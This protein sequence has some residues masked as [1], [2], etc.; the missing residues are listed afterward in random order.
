MSNRSRQRLSDFFVQRLKPGTRDVKV[1]DA[2]LPGFGIR[3]TPK[4][5]K[6]W[7]VQFDRGGKK[8][9]ATLGSLETM[10]DGDARKKAKKLR[11]LHDDGVDILAHLTEKNS[12]KDITSVVKTWEQDYAPNLKPSTVDS[13]NS[14]LKTC[15]LPR[16]GKRLVK[17]L[18]LED[19]RAFHKALKDTPTQANRAVAIL[20]RLITIAINEGWRE[21]TNPCH[22]FTRPTEKSKQRTFT[23]NELERL[24]KALTEL[25]AAKELDASVADLVRF[26]A[27][28]GLRSGEALDLTWGAVGESRNLMRFDAHKTDKGGTRPKVLPLNSHLRAILKR[29]KELRTSDYVFPSA[30]TDGRFKGMGKCWDRIREKA[31]LEPLNGEVLTLHDLRRSFRSHCGELGF[32]DSVG[33]TLLGHS[34]GK[35]KDTYIQYGP[36]GILG[37]ASQAT[38]DWMAKAMKGGKPKVGERVKPTTSNAAQQKRV[39]S[40]NNR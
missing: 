5:V 25:V 16:L 26:I 6:S 21:T 22:K 10:N 15:I 17:D 20:S 1:W 14:V 27:C 38:A 4:G 23:V 13:Y 37:E 28:S 8:V 12:A 30:I 35:V 24:E 11:D 39:R 2:D 36:E 18:S 7:I 29:R 31:E 9:N 32:P 34:L 3:V 19:V 33:E 40:T